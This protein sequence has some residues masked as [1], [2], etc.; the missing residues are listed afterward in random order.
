MKKQSRFPKD[1]EREREGRESENHQRQQSREDD[2]IPFVSRRAPFSP[3]PNVLYPS[4]S[5]SMRGMRLC[6]GQRK[7]AARRAETWKIER[8]REPRDE[9]K[10]IGRSSSLPFLSA[11]FLTFCR[12]S[13][14]AEGQG[15]RRPA[16]RA[17][18]RGAADGLASGSGGGRGA[19]TLHDRAKKG[20]RKAVAVS[21]LFRD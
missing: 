19:R 14:D 18:A 7:N 4:L 1:Q 8:Q 16:A 11:L 21:A 6:E 12:L 5:T 2:L 20:I 15:A 17:G 9:K 10:Q 3:P 13:P